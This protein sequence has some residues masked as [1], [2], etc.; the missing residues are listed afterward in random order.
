VLYLSAPETA[1]VVEVA[2]A[3]PDRPI[4]EAHEGVPWTIE[5]VR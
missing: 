5:R 2:S 1:S 4:Y 3:Y